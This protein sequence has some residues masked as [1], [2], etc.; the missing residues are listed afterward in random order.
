MSARV[1]PVKFPHQKYLNYL[2]AIDLSDEEIGRILELDDL[3]VPEVHEMARLRFSR[4]DRPTSF[5]PFDANDSDSEGWLREQ[6]ILDLF[7][8]RRYSRQAF[9]ILRSP[10][11]RQPIEALLLGGHTT[12][13][14]HDFLAKRRL[15]KAS[16]DDIATFGQY[17]WS[18]SV[19]SLNEWV[20]FLDRHPNGEVLRKIL[21]RGPGYALTA[22]D[23]FVNRVRKPMVVNEGSGRKPVP[24]QGCD[25]TTSE[26]T[27]E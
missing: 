9:R 8:G 22:A 27:S 6:G 7:R 19:L 11:L 16:E 4:A 15:P 17:F 10:V 14:V 24:Q 1:L 12:D 2:L 5:K 3:V 25:W 18:V 20:V 23:V 26:H 21:S 13:T